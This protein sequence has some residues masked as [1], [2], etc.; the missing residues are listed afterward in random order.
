[1]GGCEESRARWSSKALTSPLPALLV[2]EP[3]KPCILMAQRRV[4]SPKKIIP[5]SL[6]LFQKC[7]FLRYLM[8]N[9]SFC[10]PLNIE[11]FLLLN[12]PPVASLINSLKYCQFESTRP[13][14]AG[15]SRYALTAGLDLLVLHLFEA[16]WNFHE[17]TIGPVVEQSRE[18]H[19][20]K[21]RG[22]LM[23]W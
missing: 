19:V 3:L 16:G 23:G 20:E 1:M 10:C 12:Y 6:S 9:R 15:G 11:Q 7:L 22:C 14:N 18:G 8:T 17:L 4:E 2:P 21:R 13:V 5:I